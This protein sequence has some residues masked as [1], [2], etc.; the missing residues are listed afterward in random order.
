MATFAEFTNILPDPNNP[1][2][3]SG[4]AGGTAGP[5]YAS[6]KLASEHKMMNTRTNSG[7]L[8]SREV[9]GHKWNISIS[10]NPMTRDE[11]EPIYSFLLQKR[12]SLTPF[13][14]SL[15]QYKAPRDSTFA[16]YVLN[17]GAAPRTFT[18]EAQGVAGATNILIAGPSGYNHSSNGRAKPGDLFTIESSDSNHKKVYQVT[19]VE[20]SDIYL[21]GAAVDNDQLR[22]HFT[23]ALQRAVATGATSKIHFNDP[24]FRVILKND[25]QEYNLNKEN[26]YSFSLGLEEAQ[27]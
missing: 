5:G 16:T 14:V 25:V 21:A 6:V 23:P 9:S 20:A 24:K 8:I 2:G 4:Q 15:P 3:E 13:F 11:F 1:I 26:L 27:P 12:G 22:V 7:R 10:Y 17:S 18:M 19:R